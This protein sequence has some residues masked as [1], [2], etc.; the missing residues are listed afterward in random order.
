MHDAVAQPIEF[1]LRDAA[2]SAGAVRAFEAGGGQLHRAG[3]FAVVGEQQ[4]AFGVDVEAAD[5]DDARHVL[6]QGAEYGGAAVGILIG[7]HQADGLVIAPEARG[8]RPAHGIV[9]DEDGLAAGHLEGGRI[10]HLAIDLDAALGDH[11][12]DI[13]A[14]G[15]AGAGE[16]FGDAFAF[17]GKL[18]GHGASFR[19]SPR[20]KRCTSRAM[21]NR[22]VDRARIAAASIQ[23]VLK[24]SFMPQSI[25]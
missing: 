24:F 3:E 13:A 16:E 15:D 2:V 12:L 19:I 18:V 1:L 23:G 7:G 8:L 25:R 17:W 11:A 20:V 22:T 4:Q 5:G 9:V 21:P 6:R 14:R 10:E